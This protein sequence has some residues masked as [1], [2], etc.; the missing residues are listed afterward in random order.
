MADSLSQQEAEFRVMDA[1]GGPSPRSEP[2][3]QGGGKA[4]PC[5]EN[6]SQWSLPKEEAT[7]GGWHA[8]QEVSRLGGVKKIDKENRPKESPKQKGL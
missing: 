7:N 1:W 8:S 4:W 2:W 5:K 6:C 3:Q